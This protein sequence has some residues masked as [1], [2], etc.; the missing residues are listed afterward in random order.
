MLTGLYITLRFG[1]FISLMLAFGCVLYGARWAPVPLRRVLMLRFY[2]LLRPLLLI[3]AISTLALYLLQGNDGRG[4]DGCLA[5]RRLAG[6][7]RDPLWWSVD[8]AD[9]TGV[10][11]ACGSVDPSSSRRPPAGGPAGGTAAAFRR[12]WARR[13]ARWSHRRAA[14]DKPRCASLLRR[15][16][17]R[18]SVALY[19][20]PALGAGAGGR[21][22]SIPWRAFHI[23]GIWPSPARSPAERSMRC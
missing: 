9:P 10:D 11:R 6:G 13:Y 7:G 14:A 21:P 4:L 8:L 23:T 20:L 5:T 2:P 15:Q 22:R 19:L 1:H 16:L 18:R 3:G 17:V 12:G